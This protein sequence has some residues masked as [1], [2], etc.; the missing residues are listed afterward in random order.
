MNEQA[1]SKI[2]DPGDPRAPSGKRRKAYEPPT[3][4]VFGTIAEL[5]GQ[6]L[7][8]SGSADIVSFQPAS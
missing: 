1:D 5:T 8:S 7:K 4:T 2:R 3:L 6:Q